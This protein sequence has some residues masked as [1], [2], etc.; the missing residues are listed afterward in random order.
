MN[1]SLFQAAAA[2]NTNSRWQDVISQNL[3]SSSI[4][5]FKKNELSIA[6][7]RAGLMPTEGLGASGAPKYFTLPQSSVET[8]F[9]PG[10]IRFTGS[11]NDVAIEG[12]GFFGV[13]L[14]DGSTAYTRDGEFHINAQ[15]QLITK[16][17]Y[18][19]LGESG[20]IQ[21]DPNNSAP[22]SIS[23]TGEV[24]QGAELKG[25]LRVS[26]FEKPELLTQISGGYFLPGDPTAIGQPSSATL[27]Q[28]YLEA[29]NTSVVGEMANLM[30]AMRTFEANQRIIQMQDE[31]MA[32][33]I[34]ELGNPN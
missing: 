13:S 14:P 27:R 11:K 16:Q 29:S 20:P 3:A 34:G 22:F 31:R 7:V 12:T 5:G 17:G 10:E 18:A 25:K 6:A 15:S 19:V 21:L 26:D 28:G 4:P 23:T 30:T 32:K 8:N 2:M 24:S 33:T 1:V 9:S